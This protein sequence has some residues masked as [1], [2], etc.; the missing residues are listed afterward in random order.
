MRSCCFEYIAFLDED[1]KSNIENE[2][3]SSQH[4]NQIVS[5]SL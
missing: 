4:E 5:I 2:I 1:S 3:S